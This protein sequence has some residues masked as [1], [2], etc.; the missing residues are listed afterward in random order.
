MLF[1]DCGHYQSPGSRNDQVDS[2]KDAYFRAFPTF[3][4]LELTGDAKYFIAIACGVTKC[5]SGLARAVSDAAND[6]LIG[7][8]C[9]AA[10]SPTI[11]VLQETGAAAFA[12]LRLCQMVGVINDWH[13]DLL[14]A[15]SIHFRVLFYYRDHS[16]SRLS[17]T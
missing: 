13:L 14:A 11:K 7:D 1:E 17:N 6:V 5:E 3:E 4:D 12:F 15:G 2:A 8:Y 9:E 16:R 10:D